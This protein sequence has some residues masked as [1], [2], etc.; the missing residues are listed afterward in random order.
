MGWKVR[1]TFDYGN[2]REAALWLVDDKGTL[3]AKG[4]ARSFGSS[5]DATMV[6]TR[7]RPKLKGDKWTCVAVEDKEGGK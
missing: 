2:G 3:G 5:S 6:A 7:I 1:C 4:I